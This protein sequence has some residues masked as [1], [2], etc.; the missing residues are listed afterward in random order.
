VRARGG[1]GGGAG[2]EA[3]RRPRQGNQPKEEE[4]RGKEGGGKKKE[5]R[6]KEK[7][8]ERKGNRKKGK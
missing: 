6:E 5:K 4:W 1:K 2:L 8:K 3:R 7:A